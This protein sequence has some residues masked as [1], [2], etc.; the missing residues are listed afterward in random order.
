MAQAQVESF[1]YR[2]RASEVGVQQMNILLT[3]FID[4]FKPDLILSMKAELVHPELIKQQTAITVLWHP[5]Y[6]NPLPEWLVKLADVYDYFFTVCKGMTEEIHVGDRSIKPLWLPEAYCDFRI[7]PVNVSEAE[8]E[9]YGSDVAFIGTDKPRPIEVL[10]RVVAEGF[11]LKIWGAQVNGGWTNAGLE[12]YWM[13]YRTTDGELSKICAS[14]KIILGVSEEKKKTCDACFSARV[15]QTLGAKGFL[16]EERSKGIESMLTDYQDFVLWD[17]EDNLIERMA[18]FLGIELLYS[19][20][21]SV[22]GSDRER[23]FIA[24]E[25]YKTVKQFHTFKH[26]MET[27][28][29]TVGLWQK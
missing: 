5:D 26:R 11:N 7:K 1:D 3:D 8:K 25:G 13:G 20:G 15:Y 27:L 4:W 16:L 9:K 18:H 17:N 10:K 24:E 12:K 21:E 14:S 2:Q 19:M 23:H 28:L 22:L 29:K 6:E